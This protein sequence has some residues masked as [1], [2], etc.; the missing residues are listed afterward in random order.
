MMIERDPSQ[1]IDNV[2]TN[3]IDACF[4]FILQTSK[5]FDLY[6]IR[7]TDPCP[8]AQINSSIG[9]SKQ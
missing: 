1:S 9:I 3:D 8:H 5:H 6:L 2:T 7:Q 4:Y